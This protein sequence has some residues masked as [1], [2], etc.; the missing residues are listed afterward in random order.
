IR[1]ERLT[2]SSLMRS[3]TSGVGCGEGAACAACVAVVV[4]AATTAVKLLESSAKRSS[5][6][7]VLRLVINLRLRRLLSSGRGLARKLRVEHGGLVDE[8]GHD[9]RGLL[10]VVRL[11]ALVCVL[12]RVVRARAV[13]HLVLYELEAGQPYRVER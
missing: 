2:P 12:R 3:T 5:A 11:Y 10:H 4:C 9:G 13:I 7:V 8:G 6:A 1:R